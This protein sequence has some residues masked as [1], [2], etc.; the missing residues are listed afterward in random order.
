MCKKLRLEISS[1]MPT[2]KRS[3]QHMRPG[4]RCDATIPVWFDCSCHVLHSLRSLLSL[5][6][7]ECPRPSRAV[8]S[9]VMCLSK[10]GRPVL[11]ACQLDFQEME[12]PLFWG[13]RHYTYCVFAIGYYPPN[14][15]ILMLLLRPIDL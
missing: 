3:A 5:A 4:S 6:E 7:H 8:S 14:F 9:T 12:G 10:V 15:N 13:T 1:T 11:L 2:G